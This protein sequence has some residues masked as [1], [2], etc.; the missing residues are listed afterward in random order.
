MQSFKSLCTKAYYNYIYFFF[1]RALCS[2]TTETSKHTNPQAHRCAFACSC[3]ESGTVCV[4][5]THTH[6]LYAPYSSETTIG[7]LRMYCNV[8]INHTARI[9]VTG[10]YFTNTTICAHSKQRQQ[11]VG[12]TG[13]TE[14][15]QPTH[16]AFVCLCA[17][18]W[19]LCLTT[20]KRTEKIRPWH[21]GKQDSHQKLCIR[22][23]KTK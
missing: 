21:L 4:T 12:V 3:A 18:V 14:W 16:C 5:H 15:K 23:N 17:C 8:F 11:R 6:T 13:K 22:L 9:H 10:T 20:A 7:S 2:V 1:L 19:F